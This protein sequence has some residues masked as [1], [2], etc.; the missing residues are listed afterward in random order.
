[1]ND[2]DKLIFLKEE[3]IQ[4]Y[5]LASKDFPVELRRRF[6]VHYIKML[7]DQLNKLRLQKSKASN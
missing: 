5:R 3:E 1:M 4:K 6:S 2:I 7:E